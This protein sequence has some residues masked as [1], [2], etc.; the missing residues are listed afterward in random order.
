[1][2]VGLANMTPSPLC[3]P[4]PWYL[5]YN[6]IVSSH[7]NKSSRRALCVQTHTY[8]SLY[9]QLEHGCSLRGSYAHVL[10]N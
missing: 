7:V 2:K 6:T 9:Q 3:E 4:N 1:M 10:A 8:N 5:A